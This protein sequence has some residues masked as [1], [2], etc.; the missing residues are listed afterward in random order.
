MDTCLQ[1]YLSHCTYL[2]VAI[3]FASLSFF[4]LSTI[5]EKLFRL[6]MIGWLFL[7]ELNDFI[8]LALQINTHDPSHLNPIPKDHYQKKK[9]KVSN[10]ELSNLLYEIYT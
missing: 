1:N 8:N 3:C 9:K 6:C 10:G 2:S 5:L 7:S 4:Q